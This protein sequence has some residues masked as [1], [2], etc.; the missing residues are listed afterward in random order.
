VHRIPPPSPYTHQLIPYAHP[1]SPNSQTATAAAKYPITGPGAGFGGQGVDLADTGFGS[2]TPQYGPGTQ[3]QVVGIQ[4]DEG[5]GCV[6]GCTV[7]MQ[8]V[9]PPAQAPNVDVLLNVTWG[10][11]GGQNSAL[12]K[13]G[14][15]VAFAVPG[16]YLRVNAQNL[17]HRVLVTGSAAT[18][19]LRG[20]DAMAPHYSFAITISEGVV[21]TSLDVSRFIDNFAPAQNP[22]TG[23][24]NR[25]P[26]P[27]VIPPFARRYSL[28]LSGL[29]EGTVV[30]VTQWGPQSVIQRVDT[31]TIGATGNA[32][33]DQ[34]DLLAET[35]LLEVT[36]PGTVPMPTGTYAF[37]FTLGL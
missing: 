17:L 10:M 37:D 15:G 20:G 11:G 32:F 1:L 21:A 22:P 30:N 34:V 33:I 3:G 14:N 8:N 7:Q 36:T 25:S 5:H 35:G 18:Y 28:S 4:T 23:L 9:V 26:A 31:V 19:P 13:V 16:N 27:F 12:M 24:V 2:G 29:A 6:L